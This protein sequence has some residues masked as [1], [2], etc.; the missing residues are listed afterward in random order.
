MDVIEKFRGPAPQVP[1]GMEVSI[2][3]TPN[4]DILTRG[5]NP[6][7]DLPLV[8]RLFGLADDQLEACLLF[9]KN[10][11]TSARKGYDIK[12]IGQMG[13]EGGRPL[14]DSTQAK[15]ELAHFGAIYLTAPRKG[16]L[17][18]DDTLTSRAFGYSHKPLVLTQPHLASLA[19][20]TFEEMGCRI[21]T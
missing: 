2:V 5:F 6:T 10:S 4:P 7:R 21:S 11:E 20:E 18:K 3:T 17:I 8:A 1:S 16:Y 14:P 12:I 15:K 13:V 19:S 9:F